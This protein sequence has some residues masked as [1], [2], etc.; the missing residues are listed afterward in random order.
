MNRI[1]ALSLLVLTVVP[2]AA[3]REKAEVSK[4]QLLTIENET[5][6][7]L[8][9]VEEESF[10]KLNPQ[11]AVVL[12]WKEPL[13]RRERIIQIY[14]GGNLKNDTPELFFV[15]KKSIKRL[16]KKMEKTSFAPEPILIA[17]LRTNKPGT[18]VLCYDANGVL[19]MD[20]M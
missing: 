12:F 18:I 2:L 9:I 17:Q 4:D 8:F 16:N 20:R 1:I 3:D 6:H 10:K 13:A 15:K 11:E 7:K 19:K 5:G 14:Y